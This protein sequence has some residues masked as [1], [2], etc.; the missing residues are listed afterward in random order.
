MG[1]NTIEWSDK[2]EAV[3]PVPRDDKTVDEVA[4]LKDIIRVPTWDC[5]AASASSHS[6]KPNTLAILFKNTG[7]KNETL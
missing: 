2:H 6:G 7:F 3:R 5:S 1:F 4:D